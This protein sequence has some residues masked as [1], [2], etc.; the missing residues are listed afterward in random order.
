MKHIV[1]LALATTLAGTA[2]AATVTPS[3]PQGWTPANVRTNATVGI[4]STYKPAGEQGSLEF[5]TNTIVSGQDK[6]DYANYWGVVTGRTLG[7]ITNVGYD[8]FRDSASTTSGWFV[9]AFRLSYQTAGGQTGYLIYES[10][11]NGYPTAGPYL[12]SN[13]WNDLDITGANFWMRA[14][15][16]SR[17]IEDYDVTLAEW[18]GGFASTRGG[19]SSQLL[20]AN[21]SITGIE[22]GVGSGWGNSFRGAVDDVRLS[23]GADQISA[24]FEPNAVPEPAAWAMMVLGFGLVGSAMRRRTRTIVRFA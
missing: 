15:G 21:T 24:N 17:T 8:V 6:A 10:V 11:Y 14:F 23:F 18:A 5:T 20:D 1:A 2:F 16:P 12:P 7:N 13:T 9:P 3:N 4:T 22:I 19:V